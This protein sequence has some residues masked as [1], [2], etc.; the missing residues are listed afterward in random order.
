[1]RYESFAQPEIARLEELHLGAIDDLIDA[2]LALGRHSEVVGELE[3]L[4]AQHPLREK[5]RGQLMLALYRSG[6]QGD[7]LAVYKSGRRA[8]VEELGLEPGRGL[9][10]DLERAILNQDPTLDAVVA[11]EARRC[12][13]IRPGSTCGRSVRRPRDE[14]AELLSALGDARAG[15]GRL[16]VV[17]G[18]AGIGKSRL[19]GVALEAEARGAGVLWGRCWEAGGAPPYWPWVQALRAHV[20]VLL[21][22]FFAPSLEAG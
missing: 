7:A 8:V 2:R 16:V 4:V 9:L 19:G 13:R 1:M 14:L 22:V 15:A 3:R 20:R 5:P 6:R 10:E 18:E 11:A 21:R 17:S 12:R